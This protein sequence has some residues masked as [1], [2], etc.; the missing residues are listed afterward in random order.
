VDMDRWQHLTTRE[1]HVLQGLTP[2][3]RGHALQLLARVPGLSLSSGRRTPAR[4][5]GVGGSARSW[6]LVGRAIDATG[7]RRAIREGA[8][9]ARSL[10][11]G[12]RCT[13][14]EEVIDEGDHL[15]VA[16]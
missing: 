3:T 10:R 15:H 6:H 7:S 1:L 4:N 13:G 5:R 11:L 12:E 2:H 9:Q 16:W 14:P 8:R